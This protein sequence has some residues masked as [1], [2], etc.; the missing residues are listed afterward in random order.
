MKCI[1][2][3]VQS[4]RTVIGSHALCEKKYP[5]LKK[6]HADLQRELP[7]AWLPGFPCP[8]SG[9]ELADSAYHLRLSEYLACIACTEEAIKTSSVKDF[10]DSGVEDQVL[11]SARW[12]D[13]FTNV[14]GRPCCVICL[15]GAQETALD[16]CGHICMCLACSE[17]VR[18]C[19]MCRAPTAKSLRIFLTG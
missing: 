17:A 11:E 6:F 2:I 15:E 10:F 16:P 7:S 3:S 1:S 8:Q 13:E 12:D 5:D 18:D 4:S 9:V 14:H 19:P